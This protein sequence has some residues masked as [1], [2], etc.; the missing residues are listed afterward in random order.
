MATRGALDC[1]VQRLRNSSAPSGSPPAYLSLNGGVVVAPNLHGEVLIRN[2]IANDIAA[3]SAFRGAPLSL[4]E[5]GT[6]SG[7]GPMVLPFFVDL[8]LELSVALSRDDLVRFG[9]EIVRPCLLEH[10]PASEIIQDTEIVV[11]A[12]R[13]PKRIVRWACPCSGRTLTSRS[14]DTDLLAVIF[15]CE[16]CGA[17]YDAATGTCVTDDAP[18]PSIESLFESGAA[19]VHDSP[20]PATPVVSFKSSC[21]YRVRNKE[22]EALRIF[23]AG[24]CC[25]I[26]Y[27]GKCSCTDQPPK[28]VVPGVVT[29]QQAFSITCNIQFEAQ[30]HEVFSRYGDAAAWR[31]FCD[32]VP[33]HATGR[34]PATLRVVGTAKAAKCGVCDAHPEVMPYCVACGA[35]GRVTDVQ[36]RYDVVAVIGRSGAVRDH[37]ITVAD[38]VHACSIRLFQADSEQGFVDFEG[39]PRQVVTDADRT[40]YM[41]LLDME[42]QMKVAR[43]NK[44]QTTRSLR[45]SEMV[46]NIET[47]IRGAFPGGVYES[48]TVTRVEKTTH[49]FPRYRVS[50]DGYNSTFCHHHYSGTAKCHNSSTVWFQLIP[51]TRH[52]TSGS[53]EQRCFCGKGEPA[54]KKGV[55]RLEMSSAT[56]VLLYP[57]MRQR[58]ATLVGASVRG[59]KERWGS[60]FRAMDSMAA[61]SGLPPLSVSSIVR[62]LGVSNDAVGFVRALPADIS[63]LDDIVTSTVARRK[64]TEEKAAEEEQDGSRRRRKQ[65]RTR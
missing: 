22:A 42:K 62:N 1:L 43:S 55:T 41:A 19:T 8:D 49:M 57:A 27:T 64:S 33:L 40:A 46:Q 65:Q 10:F 39:I 50:V 6:K 2:A 51:P 4:A 17:K 38:A 7:D 9:E 36:K 47:V 32:A 59:T 34:A 35:T 30:R 54:C 29:P 37:G 52:T 18:A 45:N 60:M 56:A 12:P 14:V 61:I 16:T 44:R 58:Q 63:A 24:R 53:I 28:V 25:R 21:H 13:E 20:P 31:G 15:T 26:A 11:C 5:N 3:G 48:L 23:F